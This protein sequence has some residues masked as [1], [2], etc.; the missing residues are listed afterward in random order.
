M[1]DLGKMP[2]SRHQPTKAEMAE[3]VVI[4]GKPEEIAKAMLEGG[5][6]RKEPPPAA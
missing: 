6:D 5:E 3:V 1:N 2:A 4:D